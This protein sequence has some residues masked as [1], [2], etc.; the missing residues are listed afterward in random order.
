MRDIIRTFEGITLVPAIKMSSPEKLIRLWAHETYR[1]YSDRY[2]C[3]LS[4]KLVRPIDIVIDILS[5]LSSFSTR[6]APIFAV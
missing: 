6:N 4:A 3:H 1:I 2:E 5:I